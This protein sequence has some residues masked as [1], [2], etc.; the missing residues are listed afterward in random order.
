VAAIRPKLR[1]RLPAN[2][3]GRQNAPRA[4]TEQYLDEMNSEPGRNMM[5]DAQC[6]QTPG[7][8]V[9][10][11]GGQL[12]VILERCQGSTQIQM[13][14]RACSRMRCASQYMYWLTQRIGEQ[15]RSHTNPLS[16]F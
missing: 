11:L 16:H 1:V 4:W 2:K 14:E 15:A 7:Y 3:D 9:T 12:Q 13:W 6:S 10:I 5:R 8:C